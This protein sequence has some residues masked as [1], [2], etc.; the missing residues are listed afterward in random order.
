MTKLFLSSLAALLSGIATANAAQTFL[1]SGTGKFGLAAVL[2]PDGKT[3]AGLFVTTG[4]S[5]SLTV[6]PDTTTASFS[7]STLAF[8]GSS[9]F[10]TGT[11]EYGG[12]SGFATLTMTIDVQAGTYATGALAYEPIEYF[13][14]E[15]DF[16]VPHSPPGQFLPA[17]MVVTYAVTSEGQTTSV[18][19]VVPI[20]VDFGNSPVLDLSG[21]PGTARMAPSFGLGW[22]GQLAYAVPVITAPNGF[23]AQFFI[24]PEPSSSLLLGAGAIGFLSRRKR[25]RA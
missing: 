17:S 9:T 15:G 23:A 18:T 19:D 2:G 11:Y 5:A 6:D 3:G 21:F 24:I 16:F 4:Y 7:L 13:T 8:S 12:K 1:Y 25:S 14:F 22:G 10:T 20:T